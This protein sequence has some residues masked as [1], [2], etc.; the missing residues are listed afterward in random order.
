MN[1]PVVCAG[2]SGISQGLLVESKRSREVQNRGWCG[3]IKHPIHVCVFRVGEVKDL[4]SIIEHT[5][6]LSVITNYVW[7]GEP[8]LL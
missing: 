5:G 3:P 4:S 6:G 7:L 8:T 1:I 2:F